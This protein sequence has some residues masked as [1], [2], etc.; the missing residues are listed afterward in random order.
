MTPSRVATAVALA[1]GVVAPGCRAR[2]RDAQGLVPPDV[3]RPAAETPAPPPDRAFREGSAGERAR[4]AEA[5]AA[6]GSAEGDA[7]LAAVRQ[8]VA[9]G[10]V[11][12]PPL[13]EALAS[14]S[15]RVRSHAAY[16]LGL[17]KDRRTIDALAA[18]ATLDA[19]SIVRGEAAAS[20][21]AMGDPRGLA[22]LVDAL[23][24]PDP[25]LRVRAIDVLAEATGQRLG[26]EADGPPSE[27]AAAVRRWRAWLAQR[28]ADLV[29]PP[30]PE[31][32]PASP[33]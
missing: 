30:G 22:P 23:A 26:F 1:L 20:L 2:G 31:P 28:E 17:A 9:A 6:L 24:D 3:R 12:V 33:R 25:R 11:A 29:P 5:V 32:D 14:P 27:R 7:F 18:A 10:D 16:V 8:L 13:L 4:V 19:A 21:L 15:V